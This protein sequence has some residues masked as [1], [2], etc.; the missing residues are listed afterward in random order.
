MDILDRRIIHFQLLHL[1]QYHHCLRKTAI[2][3]I[4]I[5]IMDEEKF[6][7]FLLWTR[8]LLFHHNLQNKPI[9]TTLILKRIASIQHLILLLSNKKVHQFVPIKIRTSLHF[10]L[11]RRQFLSLEIIFRMILKLQ[12]S[13]QRKM[14][15]SLSK[16]LD[17]L[18]KSN[19]LLK[20][21]MFLKVNIFK[22]HRTQL[23]LL[24]ILPISKNTLLKESI[25]FNLHPLFKTTNKD[26]K[27]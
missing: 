4:T 26:L 20:H 23:N 15:F 12:M 21:S 5:A 24:F 16:S 13:E 9:T 3:L 17:F 19:L 11:S 2:F 14:V 18:H 22:G 10:I 8:H 25:T 27:A 6:F 1:E 7:Q